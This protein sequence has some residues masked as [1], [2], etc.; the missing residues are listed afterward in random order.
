MVQNPGFMNMATSLMQTPAFQ[1]MYVRCG[2]IEFN[3]CYSICYSTLLIGSYS[4]I[5]TELVSLGMCH[6]LL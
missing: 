5:S 6:H 4:L 2:E 1:N 3:T